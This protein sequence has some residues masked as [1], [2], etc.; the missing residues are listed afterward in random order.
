MKEAAAGTGLDLDGLGA[1]SLIILQPT[2]NPPET[3]KVQ[4][5]SFGPE[6]TFAIATTLQPL[7]TKTFIPSL[8]VWPQTVKSQAS[9]AFTE[10]YFY[11][12]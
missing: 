3:R 4:G 8:E 2:P 6:M 12:C 1:T 5:I 10:T 7:D 9:G 11:S